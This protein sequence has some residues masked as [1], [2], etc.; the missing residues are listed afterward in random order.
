MANAVLDALLARAR[1]RP[2]E[3]VLTFLS[4]SGERTE[5]SAATLAN[6]V[7][8]AANL[9]REEFDVE[10]GMPVSLTIPWHWQRMPWLVACLALGADVGVEPGA[11]IEIGSAASLADSPAADRLAVSLHPFGLPIADLPPGL[12][13]ASAEARLQ[14]DA[15]LGEDA[16]TAAWLAPAA[17]RGAPWTSGDRVLA[18]GDCGWPVILTPL[19][20]PAALVMVEAGGTAA[21]E[22]V[23]AR[24]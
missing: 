5:L 3:P 9:L 23:T 8:K 7:A 11:A 14:P 12:V 6:A 2:S 1:T 24:W 19:A 18:E 17:Q 22:G 15:F 4:A 21:S 10:P 16:D 13:D 20:T